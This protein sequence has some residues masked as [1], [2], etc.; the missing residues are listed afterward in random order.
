MGRRPDLLVACL[1]E[2][3][4]CH[5]D[6]RRVDLEFGMCRECTGLFPCVHPGVDAVLLH[7]VFGFVW[8]SSHEVDPGFDRLL[9]LATVLLL[10]GERKVAGDVV[11]VVDVVDADLV[12]QAFPSLGFV[13]HDAVCFLVSCFFCHLV[14]FVPWCFFFFCERSFPA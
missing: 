6:I 1:L 11:D 8:S 3:L 13:L 9:R 7:K 10:T 2:I 4:G 14:L 12:A 5:C